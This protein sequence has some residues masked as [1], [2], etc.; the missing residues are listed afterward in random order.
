MVK[1][2]QQLVNVVCERPLV[3]TLHLKLKISQSNLKISKSLMALFSSFLLASW[4][5]DG[6]MQKLWIFIAAFLYIF[7][8]MAYLKINAHQKNVTAPMFAVFKGIITVFPQIVSA[9]TILF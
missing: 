3:L 7:V 5:F 6:D 2:R 4:T 8:I 9:E 1:K